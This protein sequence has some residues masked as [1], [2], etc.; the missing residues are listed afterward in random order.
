MQVAKAMGIDPKGAENLLKRL[1]DT[2][3]LFRNKLNNKWRD[4]PEL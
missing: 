1:E 3:L 2:G 4:N